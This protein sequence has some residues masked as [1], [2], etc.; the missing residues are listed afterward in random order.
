MPER[1]P[2]RRA[3]HGVRFFE[4]PLFFLGGR[5]EDELV[6]HRVALQ[7]CSDGALIFRLV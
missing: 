1:F 6:E 7:A 3:V 4:R 2:A 5:P